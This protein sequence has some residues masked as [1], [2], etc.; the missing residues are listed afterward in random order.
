[1]GCFRSLDRVPRA[2][3]EFANVDD[4]ASPM[5][6]SPRRGGRRR[7][8]TARKSRFQLLPISATSPSWSRGCRQPTSGQ[9]GDCVCR[10]PRSSALCAAS[11]Y[12]GLARRLGRFHVLHGN[13]WQGSAGGG[14]AADE[15]GRCWPLLDFAGLCWTLLDIA[16][17]S[18]VYR[19]RTWGVSIAMETVCAPTADYRRRTDGVAAHVCVL[20][21][22]TWSGMCSCKVSWS[23]CLTC[24]RSWMG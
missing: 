13:E 6:H 18:G 24:C 17:A 3:E 2:A 22:K 15:S 21:T 1:L 20:H 23:I 12:P 9:D 14:R 7:A 19:R 10:R 8:G 16:V 5:D 11:K 4:G